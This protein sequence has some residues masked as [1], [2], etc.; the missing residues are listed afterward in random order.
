[1]T[2]YEFYVISQPLLLTSKDCIHDITSTIL[3]NTEHTVYD[4]TYTTLV[5]SQPLYLWQDTCNVFDMI[6]SVYEISP[7]EWMTTQRLYLTW[8]PMY[9][10]NQTHLTN[11]ITTYVHMKA[12]PLHAWHHRHFTWHHIHSCWQHAIVSISWQKL[13]F[14]HHMYNIWCHPYCV[15]D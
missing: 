2:S 14:W 9:V 5:T 4:I 8:Y 3:L 13:C 12:H 1:M 6:L 11:D 7:A 15:Y 10:C